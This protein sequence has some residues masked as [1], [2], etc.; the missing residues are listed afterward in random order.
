MCEE[1][2]FTYCSVGL[3]GQ[4]VTKEGRKELKGYGALFTYLCSRAIH[5]ET[6]ASLNTDLF[7]LCLSRFI[8]RRRNIRLLRSDS[9]SNFV[10]ASS[11][12]K[13]AFAEMN[14]QKINDFM[15]ASGGKWM[16]WKQNPPSASNMG[17]V[18]ERQVRN[19]R[20]ILT[21]LLKTHDTSLNDRSLR[22]LLIE[23]EVIANS[24]PL[25]ADLLV[26]VNSMMPL[27]PINLLTLKSR[28][29]MPPPGVFTAPDIYC[30]KHWRRVQHISNEFWSRWRKEVLA[31][32]Q[33]Q[34]KWNTIRRNCKVGDI[35]LIKEA[36]AERNSWPMAKLVATNADKHGFVRSLKLMLGTSGTTD[37]A[38]RYL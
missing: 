35:V 27:S 36:A 15:R 19:A 32:L 4:F 16:L 3:F 11:E 8:G 25:T 23:V 20:T 1:P 21:S 2:P 22:T 17:G 24:R 9:G 7:I 12:F 31:T 14:Q 26:D 28:V 38:L 34:Q 5:N 29:V 10:G 6:V 13:K 30:C 33:C 18:W 37:M